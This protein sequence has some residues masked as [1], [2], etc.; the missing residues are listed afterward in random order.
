MNKRKRHVYHTRSSVKRLKKGAGAWLWR[1]TKI[2][3]FNDLATDEPIVKDRKFVHIHD[4]GTTVLHDCLSLRK[5]IISTGKKM[6]Y[7]SRQPLNGIEMSR[8][9]KLCKKIDPDLKDIDE[10]ISRKKTIKG[11][12]QFIEFVWEDRERTIRNV[13]LQIN[14]C[15]ND[16][17]QKH[18]TSFLLNHHLMPKYKNEMHK[19]CMLDRK[20][21]SELHQSHLEVYKPDDNMFDDILSLVWFTA[22]VG[23]EGDIAQKYITLE[24]EDDEIRPCL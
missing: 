6:D 13:V 20:R 23:V 4:N 10:E 11:R 2:K 9:D 18:F 5:A 17:Y 3:N 15:I 22:H 7:Y 12:K 8:L 21:A 16:K 24:V 1:Q 19:L 14:A